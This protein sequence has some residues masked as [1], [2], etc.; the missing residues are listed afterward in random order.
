M[1]HTRTSSDPRIGAVLGGRYRLDAPLAS[2]GMATVYRGTDE[3][4]GREVAVKIMH[5]SL[6]TDP[7]FVER[8][9]REAQTAARLNHPNVVT[10][11]DCGDVD[12]TL[13]IVMELVEGTTLRELLSDFGRLDPQTARHM[14]AGVAAALDHAH[15]KGLVHRDVKPENVLVTPDGNV[16]VVDFGVAKA[17]A[18]EGSRL[19]G[20]RA[21]GTIAYVAPEQLGGEEVDARADVFALGVMTYEA[22]AGD[23]PFSGDTPTAVAA[24]RLGRS[25]P[26]PGISPAIDGAITRAMAPTPDDRFET[27]GEFARSMGGE[28]A[29]EHLRQ[30][31]EVD[32]SPTMPPLPTTLLPTGRRGAQPRT[33]RRRRWPWI[34]LAVLLLAGGAAAAYTG[35]VPRTVEVPD[36]A[37]LTPE[38]AEGALA[39]RGLAVGDTSE[40][41]S[42]SVEAG[43]II[44]TSPE[45]GVTAERES[46]VDLVVSRGPQL[47]GVPDVTGQPVEE[48]RTAIGEAGFE[49][50][51]EVEEFSDAPEGTIVRQD[52]P[53]GEARQGAEI[54]LVVSKGPELVTVPSV[55]EDPDAAEGKLENLGFEVTRVNEFSDSIPEGQVA[56]TDPGPGNEVPKGSEVTLV[57]SKGPRTF[58][59]PDLVGMQ[60]DAARA[61]AES[62]GLVVANTYAV[63]GSGNPSGEVQGQNPPA[64]TDVERGTQVDLYHAA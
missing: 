1:A 45:A 44:A 53:G 64:G 23:V 29:P 17:L 15:A 32:P 43:V 48:A 6:A 51:G 14:V 20:E 49:V 52:P 63:P 3:I 31:T 19:T 42:D 58:D 62:M 38:A 46:A 34:A 24:A 50:G 57:V 36:L 13:F 25:V 26:S 22:L 5:P 11:H 37:G 9:R 55:S 2:G 61:E 21:L 12:D 33:R 16:K 4:L 54:D 60:L 7:G 10:V 41:F 18:D 28:G 47:H 39:E 35:L 59:M 30:T 56:G 40:S 27:A 8:F